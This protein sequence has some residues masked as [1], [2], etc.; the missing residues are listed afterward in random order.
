MLEEKYLNI[1]QL[2]F[3]TNNKN[4]MYINLQSKREL[5]QEKETGSS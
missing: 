2:I 3:N 5:V 1:K 4:E